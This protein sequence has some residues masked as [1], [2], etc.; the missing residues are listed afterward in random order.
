MQQDFNSSVWLSE[1]DNHRLLRRTTTK[2]VLDS[3]LLPPEAES[4]RLASARGLS[5]AVTIGQS[6]SLIKLLLGYL[7]TV[8]LLSLTLTHTLPKKV[9]ASVSKNQDANKSIVEVA[10]AQRPQQLIP[11]SKQQQERQQ[12]PTFNNIPLLPHFLKCVF[13]LSHLPRLDRE[14]FW[15]AAFRPLA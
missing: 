7:T 14:L 13:V 12:K 10:I 15:F 1:N 5:A 3:I 4:K 8:G 11:S 6:F 9:E 2:P